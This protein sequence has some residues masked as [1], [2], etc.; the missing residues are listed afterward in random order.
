MLDMM[1][2]DVWESG[3]ARDMTPEDAHVGE[4]TR[5]MTASQNPSEPP[6]AWLLPFGVPGR[7]TLSSDTAISMVMEIPTGGKGSRRGPHQCRNTPEAGSTRPGPAQ[8]SAWMEL[9]PGSGEPWAPPSLHA[10]S[11]HGV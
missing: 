11:S 6:P 8:T 10:S 1:S 9:Q 2:E 3:G 7:A 5:E 4:R